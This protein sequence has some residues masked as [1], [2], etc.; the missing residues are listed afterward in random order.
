MS[1]ASI[2]SHLVDIHHGSQS[3]SWVVVYED[4]RARYHYENDGYRAMRYGLQASDR[5]LS[6]E[7]LVEMLKH[8]PSDLAGLFKAL[9]GFIAKLRK[10]RSDHE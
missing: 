2:M 9:F 6:V 4:G 5:W 7:E 1:I 10:Q 3:E 8:R